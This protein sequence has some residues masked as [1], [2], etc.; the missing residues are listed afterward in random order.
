MP[1]LA[2]LTAASRPGPEMSVHVRSGQPMSVEHPSG[3][4]LIARRRGARRG[5]WVLV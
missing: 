1:W 4:W 5:L 2:S 3:A